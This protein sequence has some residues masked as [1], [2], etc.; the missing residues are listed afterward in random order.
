MQSPI[1]ELKSMKLEANSQSS[2]KLAKL[3]QINETLRSNNK[4]R[5][6]TWVNKLDA[7]KDL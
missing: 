3:E 4:L 7:E 6:E 2:V 1:R 5:I